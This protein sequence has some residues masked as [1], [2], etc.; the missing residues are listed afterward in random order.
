VVLILGWA[1]FM[2]HMRPER[3]AKRAVLTQELGAIYYT[4]STRTDEPAKAGEA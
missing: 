4:P 3:R 1:T 2:G